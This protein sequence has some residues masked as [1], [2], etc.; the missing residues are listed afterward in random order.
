MRDSHGRTHGLA[1]QNQGREDPDFHSRSTPPSQS[2]SS[3]RVTLDS[4]GA[5]EVSERSKLS[6]TEP[7]VE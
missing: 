7:L 3:S 6:T 2:F 1:S 5:V 4:S